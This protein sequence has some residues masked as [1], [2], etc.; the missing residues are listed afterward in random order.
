MLDK[1]YIS[2][3]IVAKIESELE[4]STGQ[5]V[6]PSNSLKTINMKQYFVT[7]KILLFC[8]VALS[9][10]SCKKN[11]FG[12]QIPIPTSTATIVNVTPTAATILIN[13]VSFNVTP[14]VTP[15]PG[16]PISLTRN[17]TGIAV[18]PIVIVTSWAYNG[19]SYQPMNYVYNEAAGFTYNRGK[20]TFVEMDAYMAPNGQVQYTNVRLVTDHVGDWATTPTAASFIAT[21]QTV[22][23][24]R[25]VGVQKV[26]WNNAAPGYILTL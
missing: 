25:S 10:T 26:F 12:Q 4:E 1:S 13:G 22:P 9:F 5:P 6:F 23:Q 11:V 16:Q 18:G 20:A 7:S 19:Y 17:G 24:V 8:I 14:V 15:G 3:I 2:A 21:A